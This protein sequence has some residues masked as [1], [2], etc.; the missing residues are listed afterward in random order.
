MTRKH[1]RGLGAAVGSRGPI[2]L[3]YPK[4][5]MEAPGAVLRTGSSLLRGPS[6]LMQRPPQGTILTE[7]RREPITVIMVTPEGPIFKKI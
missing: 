3:V 4:P 6:T 7:P 1:S 2:R 5:D